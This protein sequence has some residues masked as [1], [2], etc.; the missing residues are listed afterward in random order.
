MFNLNKTVVD[1]DANHGCDAL[2][3][4]VVDGTGHGNKKLQLFFNICFACIL[5]VLIYSGLKCC[6]KI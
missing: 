6:P 4:A 5:F 3:I 1:E 2:K